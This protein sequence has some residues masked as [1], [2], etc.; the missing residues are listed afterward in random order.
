LRVAWGGVVW[1]GGGGGGGG[2]GD[3]AVVVS[4]CPV[5]VACVGGYGV[6]MVCCMGSLLCGLRMTASFPVDC[7]FHTCYT[8]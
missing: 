4:W 6:G 3:L 7:S 1:G 8:H 2:G 5:V